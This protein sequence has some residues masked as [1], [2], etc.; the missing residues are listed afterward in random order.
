MRFIYLIVAAI[1]VVFAFGA[2]GHIL[3]VSEDGIRDM[4]ETVGVVLLGIVG[5]FV[6]KVSLKKFNTPK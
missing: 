3:Q 1:G 6:A 4:T 2:I 5:A